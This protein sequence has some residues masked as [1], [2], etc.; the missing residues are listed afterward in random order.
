MA[1]L[2]KRHPSLNVPKTLTSH[3]IIQ[4]K[5]SNMSLKLVVYSLVMIFTRI[6]KLK[7]DLQSLAVC[8]GVCVRASVALLLRTNTAGLSASRVTNDHVAN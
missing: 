5:D 8:F 1:G 7:S 4:L 6:Y 3:C 2:E